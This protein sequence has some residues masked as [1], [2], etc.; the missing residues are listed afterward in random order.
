MENV[1]NENGMRI[2]SNT[3]LYMYVTQEIKFIHAFYYHKKKLESE[4]LW[5]SQT[6]DAKT[7]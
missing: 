4:T 7:E 1:N 3:I 5:K 6:N 2:K